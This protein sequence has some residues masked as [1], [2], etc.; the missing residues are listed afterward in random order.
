[1]AFARRNRVIVSEIDSCLA[2]IV[3]FVASHAVI[4][5]PETPSF[6]HHGFGGSLQEEQVSENYST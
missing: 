4:S 1:M 2:S 6:S 5:S 3:G